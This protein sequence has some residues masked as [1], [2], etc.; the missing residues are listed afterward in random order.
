M[1]FGLPGRELAGAVLP[2]EFPDYQRL[3]RLPAPS[4]RVTVSAADPR[5]SIL[6]FLQSTYAAGADLARWDRA[7]LERTS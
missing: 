5:A 7:S 2:H 4:Q 6:E 3:V 1:T